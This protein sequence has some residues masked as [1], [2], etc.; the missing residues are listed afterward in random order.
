M[1]KGISNETRGAALKKFKPTPERNGGLCIG[2]LV[3]VTVGEAEIKDDSPME[4]FRGHSVPRLN[5][6]FESRLDPK[7]VKPSVYNHSFLAIEHTPDSLTS[8]GDWRWRQ[9]SQTIKHFLDVYRNNAELTK[10]EV[11]KL[12]VDFV[13]EEDGVFVEQPA[14]V[15][16]AAYRKFFEN[17]VS[18]FKPEGKAI[19]KDVNGKDKL[20]WMKLLLDVKGNQVNRGDYGFSGYPGEG[21]IELYQDGV[22]PS[23]SIQINKGENIIPRVTSTAAPTPAMGEGTTQVNDDIVPSF[24]K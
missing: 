7:G 1:A 10:E 16:I 3:D 5:F 21:L 22:K 17:I 19:Y 23:I 24:M 8:E 14:D 2:T 9:L 13:D 15:V 6:T 20:V 4:S 12:A 11:E 18:M